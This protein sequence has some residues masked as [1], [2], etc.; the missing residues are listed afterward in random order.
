MKKNILL[1]LLLSILGLQACTF[2]KKM[3][4]AVATAVYSSE[5]YKESIKDTKKNVVEIQITAVGDVMVHGPQLRAQYKQALKGYDF[6]NNFKFVKPYIEDADIALC[7]LETTFAGEKLG[8]SSF[9]QFNTPD[10]LGDAL[11]DTGFD[12]I[13]T[14]NNHTLD[15]GRQG[16]FR[17]IHVLKKLGLN[18]IGTQD[19]QEEENFIIKEIKNTKVGMIAYTYE[20]PR[21][22]GHKTLNALKMPKDLENHINTF[23]YDTMKEDLEEMHQEIKRMKEDG[24]EIIVFYLHWG[25]EYQQQPN[26]QQRRMAQALASFGVDIIFGS[27]PHVL[28]PIEWIQQKEGSKNTLIVYSMGN[29]LSNQRYEIMKNRYTEDGIIVNVIFNKDL[30]NNSLSLKE[31]SYTPTWV[32]KYLE[33]GKRV[34]EVLPLTDALN[35]PTAYHLINENSLWRASNSKDNTVKLIE[36]NESIDTIFLA[37]SKSNNLK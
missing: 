33:D 4:T 2:E 35:H 20:T 6:R 8:Y 22:G 12:V 9:P 19:T 25:N 13:I 23:H 37:P 32:H 3:E 28:Q 34:Y 21:N 24:A 36:S 17:T 30:D 18:I 7:N 27:H 1:I 5:D 16:V 31:V 11:K 15:K 10:A 29:F 14:A 26:E